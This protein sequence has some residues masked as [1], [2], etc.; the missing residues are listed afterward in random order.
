MIL[1][2]MKEHTTTV[3]GT[4]SVLH[5]ATCYFSFANQL[6]VAIIIADSL[7]TLQHLPDSLSTGAKRC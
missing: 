2:H 4:C 5:V 3:C 1:V 6:W 7:L